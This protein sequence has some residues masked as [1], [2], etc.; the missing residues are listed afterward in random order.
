MTQFPDETA[1]SVRGRGV[2]HASVAG[3]LFQG[4][5]ALSQF[6]ILAVLLRYIGAER[7]GMW[8]TIWSIG[9]WAL[10]A[11]LGIQN[12][13]LTRL[14][15]RAG[16]DAA[17]TGAVL[18]SALCLVGGISVCLMVLMAVVGPWLPWASILNVESEQAVR[19]AGPVAVA[20]LLMVL[21]GLPMALGG[22]A[23]L[24]VRR[25][26]A[27]YGALTVA[28]LLCAATVWAGASSQW[29]MRW[30]AVVVMS[31]PVVAGAI[32]WALL[33]TGPGALRLGGFSR[34]HA[35]GLLRTGLSFFVL[36]LVMI[37]LLQTGSVII[38]QS[39]GAEAVTPYAAMYRL[40]GL[41]WAVYMAV[42][43]AYWPAF[44]DADHTGD[45][46]WF[47]KALRW[48]LIKTLGIWCFA[49]AGIY[50]IGDTF[51]RW[52]LGDE[53]LPSTALKVWMIVFVGVHGLLIW[54]T[55]PLKGVGRL[56]G[57][58]VSGAVMM[59]VFIPLAVWLCGRYGAAGV[60]I[61]Q[62]VVIVLIGLPVNALSLR[63]VVRG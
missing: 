23:L 8:T 24:A 28:H 3:T 7:F 59:V 22:A 9:I 37:G 4:V 5:Y 60:P 25:G 17:A 32:Q 39:Q 19:E 54:L 26:L 1:A 35:A 57:Q 38:A 2:L 6:V 21:L 47:G 49:A 36:E 45:R 33:L 43:F 40:I 18:G 63:R 10:L 31:P 11:N 46:D 13:L 16:S 42:A 55:T 56:R 51:I 20:A 58:V 14:G 41:V 30:L 29:P 50:I 34:S 53:A 12:A 48:S 62:T 44:G 27:S 15:Q 52:W 61:A